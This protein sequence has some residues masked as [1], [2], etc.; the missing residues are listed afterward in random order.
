MPLSRNFEE[1]YVLNK[2]IKK[3]CISYYNRWLYFAWCF[4]SLGLKPGSMDALDAARHNKTRM[5]EERQ[6]VMQI[7]EPG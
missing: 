5:D 4:Q 6:N 7:A 2:E 3:Y 1:S